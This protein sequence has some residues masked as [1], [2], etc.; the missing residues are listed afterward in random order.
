MIEMKTGILHFNYCQTSD[1]NC[2]YSPWV[3]I[4]SNMTTRKRK[5]L[6]MKLFVKRKHISS[7]FCQGSLLMRISMIKK[8]QLSNWKTWKTLVLTPITLRLN[9]SI[10]RNIRRHQKESSYRYQLFK[11]PPVFMKR[12]TPTV[13]HSNLLLMVVL[14]ISVFSKPRQQVLQIWTRPILQRKLAKK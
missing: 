5:I 14:S 8:W 13:I 3:A 9:V 12:N 11:F 4:F 1:K 10:V 6:T 7:M 2:R